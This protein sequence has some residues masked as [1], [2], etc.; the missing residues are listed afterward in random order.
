MYLHRGS[1]GTKVSYLSI[2]LGV[3]PRDHFDEELRQ[4]VIAFQ[5]RNGLVPDGIA[6]SKTWNK[7]L[8]NNASDAI[9]AV[10]QPFISKKVKTDKPL[11]DV[12]KFV[13][14]LTHKFRRNDHTKLY[15]TE[16]FREVR[17][18]VNKLDLD[19]NLDLCHFLGQMYQETGRGLVVTENLNYTAQALQGIFRFYRRNPALAYTHGRTYEHK[20]EQ[21][22]IANHAYAN[23]YG[24]NVPS[25]GDG[26]RYKGRGSA[27][28]T[29]LNNYVKA[30]KWI[31]DNL[32]AN[33]PD[34]VEHPGQISSPKYA[35]LFGAVF[36]KSSGASS[37]A[38][39]A[40]GV[41]HKN[42]S[43]SITEVYNAYTDSYE[44]RWANTKVFSKLLG[45]KHD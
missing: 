21:A 31:K 27:H 10:K 18:H 37:K 23:R 20:A 35:I 9:K 36:W 7:L 44:K 24:N 43:Y 6:G 19:T 33:Y 12:D 4:S 28:T 42:D 14:M 39:K 29:F 11:D 25:S 2:L 17:K 41:L 5:K 22:M 30:T 15:L 26:W 34:F 40:L 3:T 8:G 38:N 16:G 32:G 13:H 45:V 1:S